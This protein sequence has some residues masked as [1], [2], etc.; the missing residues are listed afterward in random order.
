MFRFLLGI[1]LATS[2]HAEFQIDVDP[3]TLPAGATVTDVI[4]NI[5]SDAVNADYSSVISGPSGQPL[6]WHAV[7]QVDDQVTSPSPF[8]SWTLVLDCGGTVM[9]ADSVFTPMTSFYIPGPN[10]PPV[11][12]TQFSGLDPN[13]FCVDVEVR[14]TFPEGFGLMSV[15]PNP[16]NPTTRIQYNLPTA[17]EMVLTLHDLRGSRI[18]ELVRGNLD[19]GDG[20]IQLDGSDLASGLY[21]LELVQG[22]RRSVRTV[23]LIK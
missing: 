18:R 9:T 23:T 3:L 4:A 12:P 13:D 6:M 11:G 2:T 17:G 7:W 5:G 19:A 22:D 10:N 21:L 15:S 8:R 20:E 16:F 14:A 1:L